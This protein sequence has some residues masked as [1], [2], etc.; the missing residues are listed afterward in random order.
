MIVSNYF[1]H[2]KIKALL[3]SRVGRKTIFT[4]FEKAK[5]V[6]IAYLYK[7]KA[8]IEPCIGRLKSMGKKVMQLVFVEEAKVDL[9]PNPQIVYITKKGLNAWG[10]PNGASLRAASAL[11]ADILIDLSSARS[12]PLI[13]VELLNLSLLKVGPKW[14]D[15]SEYD[16]TIDLPKG[17]DASSMLDCVILYGKQFGK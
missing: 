15:E 9:Q 10:F 6:V 1:L 11:K 3:A 16:F 5:S 12:L 13:Y 17:K 2:R 14:S 4:S 7:D 8:A